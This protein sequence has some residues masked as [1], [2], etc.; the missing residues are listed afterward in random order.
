M[1]TAK[2]APSGKTADANAPN[3]ALRRHRPFY[4]A[5]I[6]GLIVLGA[7]WFLLP[8]FAIAAGANAFFLAYLVL[9]FMQLPHLSADFLKTHAKESDAPVLVIFIVTGA[10]LMVSIASLFILVNSAGTPDPVRLVLSVMSVVLSWF[11]IHTMTALHYAYEYYERTETSPGGDGGRDVVGGLEFPGAD[12]PD[13]P[14]FLYFSYVVGMTAQ[15]ADVRVE[16]NAMRKLVTIHGVFSFFF[17][18]V[19][20]AATVNVVVSMGGT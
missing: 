8:V 7:A 17:N 19:I 12:E 20:V 13:G 11:A 2:G 14:S 5:A 9:T 18:T 10:A 4:I 15:V 3:P 16:S 6:A 1:A